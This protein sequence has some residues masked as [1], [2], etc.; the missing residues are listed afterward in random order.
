V[1]DK[2]VTSPKRWR[3]D[4]TIPAPARSRKRTVGGS[5]VLRADEYPRRVSR[6]RD[7]RAAS[8]PWNPWQPPTRETLI[9]RQIREAREAGAFDDLPFRG[10]RIPLEDDSAA[11]DWAL[12]NHILKNA[13]M[14]PPWIAT[15][16]DVRDL[17]ARR[18]AILE[19]APRAGSSIARERDRRELTRVVE[20]AN[21]SIAIL[22]SEAP[23]D[24]QHR[25]RLDL[26]RELARLAAAHEAPRLAP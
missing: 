9:D 1:I 26:E 22:N 13:N 7:P 18:D 3:S 16:R 4:P 20:E 21:R 12:A 14:V 5:I 23:T 25:R 10:E 19:R 24:R 8:G 6:S 2:R 15:D 11:G 17:L